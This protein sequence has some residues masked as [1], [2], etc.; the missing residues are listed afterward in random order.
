MF[1]HSQSRRKA[2]ESHATSNPGAEWRRFAPTRALL[3]FKVR[4]MMP[5]W[6]LDF[7]ARESKLGSRH[8]PHQPD[9]RA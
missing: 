7:A 2:N 3:G 9:N 6:V 1:S 5:L 8:D 4:W